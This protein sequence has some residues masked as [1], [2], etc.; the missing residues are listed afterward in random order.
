MGLPRFRV[1]VPALLLR[2]WGLSQALRLLGAVFGSCPAVAPGPV[3]GPGLA[4]ASV[5]GSV[6]GLPPGPVSSPDSVPVSV[7]PAPPGSD[8]TPPKVVCAPPRLVFCAKAA[9]ALTVVDPPPVPAPRTRVGGGAVEEMADLAAS[10]ELFSP[11]P[12]SEAAVLVEEAPLLSVE[13]EAMPTSVDLLTPMDWG[14]SIQPSS[15]VER[16]G[17]EWARVAIRKRAS[18]GEI[19]CPR[20]VK[21]A[22]II[23]VNRFEVLAGRRKGIWTWKWGHCQLPGQLG[24]RGLTETMGMAHGPSEDG[25]AGMD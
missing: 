14:D 16:V 23:T 15:P 3:T 18:S 9:R 19:D 6:L 21:A 11:L 8:C 25:E 2:T 13:G 5:P 12:G 10:P 24:C 1:L 20:V 7:P 22:P 17:A 4:S